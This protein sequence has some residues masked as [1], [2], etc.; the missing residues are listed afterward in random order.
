MSAEYACQT[1]GYDHGPG[2]VAEKCRLNAISMPYTVRRFGAIC[3]AAPGA[4]SAARTPPGYAQP[5]GKLVD[6][7][8]GGQTVRRRRAPITHQE[9]RE[10]AKSDANNCRQLHRIGGGYR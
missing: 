10:M 8:F 2:A 3:D 9:A 7:G 5:T 1:T 4:G 6:I